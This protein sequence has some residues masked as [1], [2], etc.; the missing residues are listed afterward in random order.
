MS[1]TTDILKHFGLSF[2]AERIDSRP[3]GLGDIA[4]TGPMVNTHWAEVENRH[5]RHWRCEFRTLASDFCLVAFF[6]QGSAIT[7]DPTGAEV[8]GCLASDARSAVDCTDVLD[9]ASEFGWDLDSPE[10][11]NQLRKVFA[12]CCETLENLDRLLGEDGREELFSTDPEA[13]EPES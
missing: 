10:Q 7:E 6:S 1:N 11:I 13:F 5:R 4:T 2:R 9:F 12:G 3:D 8:L